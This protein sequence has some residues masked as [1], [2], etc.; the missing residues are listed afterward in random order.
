MKSIEKMEANQIIIN[1][2]YDRLSS[3]DDIKRNQACTDALSVIE[4]TADNNIKNHLIEMI[5]F[6]LIDAKR[7]DEAKRCI[8][9][10]IQSP[11]YYYGIKG[12]VA[13]IEYCKR[14]VPENLEA[15]IRDTIDYSKTNHHSADYAIANLEYAKYNYINSRYHDCIK[16]MGAVQE[17]AEELKNIRFEIV[18]KYY[19]ALSLHRIGQINMALEMLREVTDLACDINSQNAAMF[20]E[21][22]R[23]VLLN[24]VGRDEEARNIIRQWCDNFETQL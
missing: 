10:L 17:V 18:A 23:A 2:I 3:G 12:H 6:H 14:C 19:T 16:V 11:D 4:K 5:V 9:D 21:M 7:F 24:E 1:E 13:Y 20:S 22:K 8:E 15:A